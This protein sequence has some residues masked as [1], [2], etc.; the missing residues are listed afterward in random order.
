MSC[1]AARALERVIRLSYGR[2]V[3][4]LAARTGNIQDAED[5]LGD[6]LIAALDAWSGSG[7]P[8]HPEAWLLAAARRR[9][10]DAWRSGEVARKHADHLMLLD[11][12]RTAMPEG[13]L[14]DERLTLML[15][16]AHPAIDP[17]LRTPLI[18]QTVLGLDAKRMASAFL[19]S[20]ATLGQRLSRAKHKIATAGIGF[21]MLG[22][23][24]LAERLPHLLDAIYAAYSVGYDGLPT[25]DRKAAGLTDEAVWLASL[26]CQCAPD[27]AEAHGLLSLMLFCEA[28]RPARIDPTTGRFMPLDRQDTALWDARLLVDAERSLANARRNLTLGRYQLEAAIQSVHAARRVTGVTAWSELQLLYEGLVLVSPTVGA[29]TGRAV[30]ISEAQGVPQGLGA[31]DAIDPR[32]SA[33]YQAWWAVRAHFLAR[34][35]DAAAASDAFDRASGLTE[36]A[37]VRAYLF[38]EKCKLG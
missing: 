17:A 29:F 25:G 32:L 5:A 15:A 38:E 11:Q 6:A 12:E 8:H 21:E 37:A 27:A 35:G 22:R 16:C 7:A 20:P 24:A 31:L 10:T 4:R 13:V 33:D 28:R 36:D 9:W 1:D 14:P 30:A 23:E 3:A 34:I 18:L 26:I 19:I 2:L